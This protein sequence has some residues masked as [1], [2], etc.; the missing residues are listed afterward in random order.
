M[1]ALLIRPLFSDSGFQIHT[2]VQ[3][4]DYF[5]FIRSGDPVKDDM[6]TRPQSVHSLGHLGVMPSC[7][8]M[9]RNIPTTF[10]GSKSTA[11]PL[12]KP[13]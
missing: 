12:S 10:V 4:S 11:T 6:F 3:D 5:D 13:S 1:G 7:Q 9:L 8:R 2:A